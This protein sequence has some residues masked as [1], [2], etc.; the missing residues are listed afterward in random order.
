L[1][2]I[3]LLLKVRIPAW[4]VLILAIGGTLIMVF[5]KYVLDRRLKGYEKDLE[6]VQERHKKKL[7]ALDEINWALT[8]FDHALNHLEDGDCGYASSLDHSYKK[9]RETARKHE[10]LIGADFYQAVI[11]TT[12]QG[13]TILQ[14]SFTMTEDGLERLKEVG[15][16]DSELELLRHVVGRMVPVTNPKELEEILNDRAFR[17]HKRSI[18]GTCRISNEFD[19][20]GYHEAKR[21]LWDLRDSLLRTLPRPC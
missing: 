10:A 12:A 17:V 7:D 16:P 11:E 3:D 6:F 18:F 14:A 15:V 1:N 20:H 13:K 8:E 2:L 19:R 5:Y 9:A 4:L 21:R